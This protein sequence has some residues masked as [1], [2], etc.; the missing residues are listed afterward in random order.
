[1]MV[2]LAVVQL[3]DVVTCATGALLVGGQELDKLWGPTA[4][5]VFVVVRVS[6]D[7]VVEGTL[8]DVVMGLGSER[9]LW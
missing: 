3:T 2:L 1:M 4:V 7:C 8:D 9:V 5:V 6:V